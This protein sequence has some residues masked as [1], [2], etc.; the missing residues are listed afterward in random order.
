MKISKVYLLLIIYLLIII[1]DGNSIDEQPISGPESRANNLAEIFSSLNNTANIVLAIDSSASMDDGFQS[2]KEVALEFLEAL[3]NNQD[4]NLKV[5]YVSWRHAPVSSSP[6]LSSKFSGLPEEIRKIDFTGNTCLRMGINRSLDLLRNE[7]P[8]SGY[9]IIVIISDGEE[10]CNTG[11][12]TC[13]EFAK[14]FPD[15]VYVYTIQTRTSERGSTLLKC[16]ERPID[17]DPLNGISTKDQIPIPQLK[18]NP[19]LADHRS[20]EDLK[21]NFDFE[22]Q[23][24]NISRR[25]ADTNITISKSIVSGEFG[26]KVKLKL[27]A[28]GIKDIKSGVV[29][30]VD[31]SG[32]MGLGGNPRYGE[33][34]RNSM[35]KILDAIEE[36]MPNSNISIISWDNDTDFAYGPLSGGNGIAAMV[37][38]SR[39][40]EEIAD[41]DV[42]T[43]KCPYDKFLYS[44]PANGLP[45]SS[46]LRI[47]DFLFTKKL[48]PTNHYYCYENEST[49]LSIGL[50]S[51]IKALDNSSFI[52]DRNRLDATRKL[53]ILIVGRSEFSNC[54]DD[55]IKEAKRKYYDIN[56]VGIGVVDGSMMEKELIKIAGGERN[57]NYSTGSSGWT[58][59]AVDQVIKDALYEFSRSNIT[60]D[61]TVVE[62][63]Y[64]YLRL[65]NDSIKVSINNVELSK[66]LINREIQVN[67]DNTTTLRIA[68][69]RN[70]N[71]KPS[72]VIEIFFDTYLDLSMP[73]GMSSSRTQKKY[74]INMS[75]PT[76]GVS[77]YWLA[78]GQSYTIPLPENS[79]N[80][81]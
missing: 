78:N 5:G 34:I 50:E 2:A 53:I 22:I 17:I 27:T 16:M 21:A 80:I 47:F 75:S 74:T 7:T 66:D 30:S 68:L 38:I 79:L 1:A 8:N 43:C 23:S 3:G 19:I 33:H 24:F 25:D 9:N 62:T 71:I 56:T 32:S 77:Y 72:D 67:S 64:P 4:R 52:Q 46:L 18:V 12:L 61:L 15:D 81:Y 59:E 65:N 31:S 42:F 69:N 26:P 37:P 49:N 10:N 35:P 51:A 40:K 36:Y 20:K 48:Q 60:N 76:S 14:I 73:L 58:S 63:L 39:A 70:I 41:N 6:N 13:S 11:N 55:L 54:D 44:I 57:Y 29:I 28:P 45:D